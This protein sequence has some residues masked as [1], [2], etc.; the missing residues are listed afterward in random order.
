MNATKFSGKRFRHAFVASNTRRG[1]AYQLRAMRLAINMSQGDIGKLASKPQNVISRLENPRYGKVSVQTLLELAEAFDVAL[2][3]KFVPFSRLL[4]ETKNLSQ[5][6][7][8]PLAFKEEQAQ[9]R[10]NSMFGE[11]YGGQLIHDDVF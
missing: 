1:I 3:V 5:M 4:T 9:A 6:V 2:L 8:A 11:L 10:S 7:L